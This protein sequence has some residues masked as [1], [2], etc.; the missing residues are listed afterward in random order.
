M[1][2]PSGTDGASGMIA[3]GVHSARVIEPGVRH[4]VL[5]ERHVVGDHLDDAMAGGPWLAP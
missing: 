3:S 1:D 5:E 2:P 4:G